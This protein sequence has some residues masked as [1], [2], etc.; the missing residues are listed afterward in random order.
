MDMDSLRL[1]RVIKTACNNRRREKS[2]ER[3]HKRRRPQPMEVIYSRMINTIYLHNLLRVSFPD[4][5]FIG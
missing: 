4:N 3:N 2:A 1:G 5:E